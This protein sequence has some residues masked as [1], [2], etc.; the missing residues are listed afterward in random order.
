MKD[1]L[2]NH[3]NTFLSL[4]V[5]LQE[6]III[7]AQDTSIVYANPVALNLLEVTAEELLDN[8]TGKNDWYFIDE[9]YNRISQE[10]Y[11]VNKIFKTHESIEHQLIGIQF[12]PDNIR[13][14][15]LN[16]AISFDEDA[17]PIVL[18]LLNEVTS[19]KNAFDKAELFHNLVNRTDVGV[20][21]CDPNQK[22]NPIIYV[23]EAFTTLTGYTQEE[24]IGK[25]CRFL[26]NQDTD[27]KE[28]E[29]VRKA[30][31][32]V[33]SCSATL[34]NYTKDG[35]LFYNLL[36]ITPYFKNEKL[37]YFIGIQH[38]ITKQK[39]QEL[40]IQSIL[41]AQ[42]NLVFVSDTDNLI[43]ANDAL[44]RFFGFDS[45]E[46]FNEKSS[47]VSKYFLEDKEYFHLGKLRAGETWIEY[48]L[49]LESSQRVVKINSLTSGEKYFQIDIKEIINT[50]Y[51][52]T[53]NDITKTI[54]KE[55]LLTTIAYHDNL[56]NAFNRQYFYEIFMAQKFDRRIGYGIIMLD[57]D[58]FKSLNDTYG[59]PAGDEVL[60]SL[61]LTLQEVLRDNDML[62]R[63]GGEEFIIVLEIKNLKDLKK[64]AK[65]LCKKIADI[66]IEGIRRFTASLGATLVKNDEN[67]D[68]SIQR[69]DE[70]LYQAKAQGKNRVVLL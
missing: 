64:I 16:G 53:L 56:T 69:A 22:D 35:K 68:S 54:V 50:K 23:N 21:L 62:I 3:T 43:Y 59:H 8:D 63:W 39:E 7:H 25:N 9:E 12:S 57:I 26:Q 13:W 58:N 42:T 60:K 46:G 67:I 17:K 28:L 38:D 55:K 30:I 18:I 65:K 34:R 70:G 14:V 37:L 15:D 52:I 47:C 20:T 4:L 27:Q 1:F 10:E 48:L 32:E 6:G 24:S 11:P 49:K 33:R 19:R 40:Y 45:L 36:N 5:K 41:N 51:V 2:K 31:Q 44:L 29:E 66:N 61:S